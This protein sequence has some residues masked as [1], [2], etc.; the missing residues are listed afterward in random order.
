MKDQ[1]KP[2][3][4]TCYH[5]GLLISKLAQSLSIINSQQIKFQKLNIVFIQTGPAAVR[6]RGV[7]NVD[8]FVPLASLLPA[9]AGVPSSQRKVFWIFKQK[10]SGVKFF[11]AGPQVLHLTGSFQITSEE[12]RVI[13]NRKFAIIMTATSGTTTMARAIP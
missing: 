10:H 1:S 2:K 9:A 3:L 12:C 11:K 13:A 6:H 8:H 7:P 5:P 4:I